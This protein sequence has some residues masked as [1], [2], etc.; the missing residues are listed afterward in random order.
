MPIRQFMQNLVRPS[1]QESD[2]Q[3]I[4]I[5]LMGGSA[6]GKTSYFQGI[7]ESMVNKSVQLGNGGLIGGFA[8]KRHGGHGG[9]IH[10]AGNGD[11]SFPYVGVLGIGINIGLHVPGIRR[12]EAHADHAP[13]QGRDGGQGRADTQ[14]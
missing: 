9:L 6:S 7:M 14:T 11:G 5:A 13:Q 4:S 1:V 8:A 10:A 2:L 12:G 3:T